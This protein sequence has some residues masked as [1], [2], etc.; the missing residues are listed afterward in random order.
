MLTSEE[1]YRYATLR[2]SGRIGVLWDGNQHGVWY[3]AAPGALGIFRR[4]NASFIGLTRFRE[5]LENA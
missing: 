3:S 1:C 4:D 2:R 5:M